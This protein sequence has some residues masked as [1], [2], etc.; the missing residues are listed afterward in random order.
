[1]QYYRPFPIHPPKNEAAGAKPAASL[2]ELAPGRGSVAADARK[3]LRIVRLR[4]VLEGPLVLESHR[5]RTQMAVARKCDGRRLVRALRRRHRFVI[6]R[7]AVGEVRVEP[8]R[9]SDG[10]GA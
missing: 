9:E 10:G 8:V 2:D 5:R 3:R 4:L 1:M 6:G 7:I